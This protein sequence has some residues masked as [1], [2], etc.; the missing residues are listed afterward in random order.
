M[1]LQQAV[2]RDKAEAAER[3]VLSELVPAAA[4]ADVEATTAATTSR[5]REAAHDRAQA[6]LGE[7]G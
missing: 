5:V 1:A 2:G 3:I 4:A 7:L 6:E